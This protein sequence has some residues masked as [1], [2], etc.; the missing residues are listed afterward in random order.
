MSGFRRPQDTP[1][2]PGKGQRE[3]IPLAP[4]R[5]VGDLG[6]RPLSS[7]D[8]EG[9]FHPLRRRGSHPVE[10]RMRKRG[11]KPPAALRV[12]IETAASPVTAQGQSFNVHVLNTVTR[13]VEE[14]YRAIRPRGWCRRGRIPP[15][16]AEKTSAQRKGQSNSGEQPGLGKRNSLP[17]CSFEKQ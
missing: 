6:R 16:A 1:G 17:L 12:V 15:Q 9:I 3:R 7:D 10:L 8:R 14:C 11:D 2:Q 4:L 5:R 13:K